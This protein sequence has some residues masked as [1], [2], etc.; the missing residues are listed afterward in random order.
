MSSR[1]PSDLVEHI[2]HAVM[3]FLYGVCEA[4]FGN[5]SPIYLEQD[6]G[7][8]MSEAALALSVF[9][10]MV[11]AGRVLFALTAIWFRPQA[12]HMVSSS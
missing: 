8:A 2:F 3:V 5:W 4:T 10:G 6:A 1:V 12:L 11:T 9:W 7:L